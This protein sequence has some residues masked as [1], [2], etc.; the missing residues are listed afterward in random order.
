M[1]TNTQFALIDDFKEELLSIVD[2]WLGMDIP[3]EGTEDYERW[4]SDLAQ[5]EAVNTIEDVID[6]L[7]YSGKDVIEFFEISRFDTDLIPSK[8][9][10]DLQKSSME[11]PSSSTHEIKNKNSNSRNLVLIN[12]RKTPGGM[13][14]MK[15]YKVISQ[16]LNSSN[17]K[18]CEDTQKGVFLVETEVNED[19]FRKIL[20]QNGVP[21]HWVQYVRLDDPIV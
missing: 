10:N 1:A 14:N 4:Q 16:A 21:S 8:I 2:E 19:E 18:N 7:E 9:M 6:F 3:E 15:F 13:A 5:I 11:E 20:Q 17:R 12:I